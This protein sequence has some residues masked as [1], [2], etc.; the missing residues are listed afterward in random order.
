MQPLLS[1]VELNQ[2]FG[3]LGIAE[4]AAG[5]G[6]L[7][8]VQIT[9]AVAAGQI[10]LHGAHV[11][12]WRP[13]KADE[14]LFLSSQSIWHDGKAIRGGVPICFPWFGDKSDDPTAPAH[15]FVRTKAWTL[16]SIANA[17]NVVTV[18][19]STA[20]DD[21]TKRWWP[22]DFHTVYRASFGADLKLELEVQNTGA[23]AI[24]F[25]EALHAYFKVGDVRFARI[26]GLD[27]VHYL[28]KTDQY[29]EKIQ[30][31]DVEI[32]SET[33][34][35]YLETQSPLELLDPVLHHRIKV[36]KEYSHTTVIWNPWADKGKAMSDLGRDQ[37]TQM[38]CIETSNVGESAVQLAPGGIHRMCAVI[39]AAADDDDEPI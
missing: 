2:R 35:I 31:G 22:A 39:S 4:V 12:S 10:Y 19:M 18:T 38:L 13:K 28:D 34:R 11:T 3:I 24:R 14:A 33:D 30:K 1:V 17:E 9:S 20:S 7:P 29:R 37:W 5:E 8:C 21:S 15:G 25:E 23:T 32:T 27:A 26:G 36:A 6:G 16:D